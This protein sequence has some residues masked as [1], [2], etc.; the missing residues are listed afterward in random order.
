MTPF[1][2]FPDISTF[3][4]MEAG[5]SDSELAISSDILLA[6]SPPHPG[7]LNAMINSI[8]ILNTVLVVCFNIGFVASL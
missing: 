6:T 8:A 5:S 7:I 1:M 3:G 2:A 4:V